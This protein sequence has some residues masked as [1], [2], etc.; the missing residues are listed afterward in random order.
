MEK[1]VDCYGMSEGE[2]TWFVGIRKAWKVL[3]YQYFKI[4]SL[5]T[6]KIKIGH[7][8]S[9]ICVNEVKLYR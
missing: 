4:Q 1:V 9:D 2:E 8:K 3:Q 5:N 6:W 7:G